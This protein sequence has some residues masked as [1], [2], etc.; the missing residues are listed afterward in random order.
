MATEGSRTNDTLLD[1]TSPTPLWAQLRDALRRRI[2]HDEWPEG[3]LLPPEVQLCREYGVSRITAARA[4]NELVREGLLERR[5]GKGTVVVAPARRPRAPAALAF[6]MQQLDREWALEI[7][8][9][10]ERAAAAARHFALLASTHG[11]QRLDAMRLRALIADHARALALN[12]VHLDPEALALLQ[13]QCRPRVPFT[14]V[15]PYDPAVATDRV[16]PDNVTAGMLATQHL[17]DLGHQRIA[18]L[19]PGEE[20][21][22]T[23]TSYADRL[24]GYRATLAARRVAA[25]G[26]PGPVEPAVPTGEECDALVLR[27]ALPKE[28][29]DE[30]RRDRLVAFL[31]RTNATAA[32][33]TN[34][35]LAVLVMRYLRTAG[36]R[37]PQHL[38]LVGIS[39][40]RV[41]ALVDVPLTTVHIPAAALGEAA[42]RLLL[43]RLEGDQSPPMEVVI[44]VRL[45]VRE[46][47]GA[48]LQGMVLQPASGSATGR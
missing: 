21:M 18:F 36:L 15:G 20:P 28:L 38:A 13:S 10:F 5:R 29:S 16:I 8:A 43:R 6:V 48:R 45:V 41:A 44:P 19:G 24:A 11:Q 31:E 30:E 32:V 9:G 3:A 17:L 23:N 39:D 47:C 22:V 12:N 37:V 2:I 35:T 14:F 25:A 27:D 4:L 26:A 7:Y 46:S 33:T 40:E 1:P 42:A 34:D